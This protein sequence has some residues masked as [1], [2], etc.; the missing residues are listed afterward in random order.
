MADEF[1]VFDKW[2]EYLEWLLDLTGKFPKNIRFTLTTRVDNTALDILEDIILYRYDPGARKTG[3]KD[4]NIKFEKLRVFLR[5]CY[6]KKYTSHQQHEHAILRL[7]EVGRI[8][9]T[10]LKGEK[11][12]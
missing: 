2:V 11:S 4:I 5:I 6:R 10:W 1:L 7:N 12:K 8:A 3:F 9:G